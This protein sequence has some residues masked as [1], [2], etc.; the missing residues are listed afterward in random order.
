MQSSN[1]LSNERVGECCSVIKTYM[2]SIPETT[3]A[4]RGKALQN[5]AQKLSQPVHK[6]N[7]S[8]ISPY[9]QTSAHR[10]DSTPAR[11]RRITH[12]LIPK[13]FVD[14]LFWHDLVFRDLCSFFLY[15]NA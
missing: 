3:S 8:I 15:V 11:A 4:Q 9:F 2:L 12:C 13:L 1:T 5:L 14:S 6:H 7:F 10:Q